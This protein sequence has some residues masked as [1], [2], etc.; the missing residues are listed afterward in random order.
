MNTYGLVRVST[1]KQ[2]DNPSL[3][4]QTKRIKDY[5]DMF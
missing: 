5:C 1:L 4:F 2:K 3:E